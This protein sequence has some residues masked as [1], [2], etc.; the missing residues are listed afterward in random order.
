M[1][2]AV[3]HAFTWLGLHRLTLEVFGHNEPAIKLY[4]KLCVKY[5]FCSS[6]SAAYFHSQGI[7]GRRKEEGVELDKRQVGGLCDHGH[8]GS[9]VG[10]EEGWECKSIAQSIDVYNI[11]GQMGVRGRVQPFEFF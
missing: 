5:S 8:I 11:A 7:C 10:S 6:D 4:R 9:R 2:F 1:S 3:E